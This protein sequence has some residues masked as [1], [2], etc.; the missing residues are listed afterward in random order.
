MMCYTSGM[1]SLAD[2]GLI[3]NCQVAAHV[4]RDGAIVWCCM[5]R[6]DSAPV[7][8]ALL[9]EAG[10]QFTIGPATP[11]AG[12]AGPIVNCPP[13]SSRRAPNTGAESKRGMQHQTIAPSRRT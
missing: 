9:D 4:R 12:A 11:A 13:A 3:G 2:L 8:G 5:P 10:G 6:F 7:F 1:S